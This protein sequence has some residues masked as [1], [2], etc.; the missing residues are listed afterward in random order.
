M[1]LILTHRFV[2]FHSKCEL[3]SFL[4]LC[5]FPIILHSAVH[6]DIL[7]G[8]QKKENVHKRIYC[9]NGSCI[10]H[11]YSM[12]YSSLL[13]INLTSLRTAG[14]NLLGCFASNE[15]SRQALIRD[16]YKS[17][18]IKTSSFD[19]PNRGKKYI[20]ICSILYL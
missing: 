16:S 18:N 19:F 6:T 4:C 1:Y 8:S 2:H 14:N 7:P 20:L 9:W 13:E 12:S 5:A 3:I 10:Y 17:D 11:I 15:F